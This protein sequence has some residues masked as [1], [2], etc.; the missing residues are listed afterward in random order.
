[1]VWTRPVRRLLPQSRQQMGV[2][3]PGLSKGGGEKWSDAEY[4]LKV[5]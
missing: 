2:V 1:M 4:T 5:K 3:N